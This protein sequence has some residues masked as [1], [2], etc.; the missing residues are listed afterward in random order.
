MWCTLAD[1]GTG[2]GYF[3]MGIFRGENFCTDNSPRQHQK[4]KELHAFETMNECNSVL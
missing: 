1:P 3:R 4:I 2:G